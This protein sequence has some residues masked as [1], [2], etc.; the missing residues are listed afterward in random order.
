MIDSE[1]QNKIA[2]VVT[3]YKERALDVM[4]NGNPV[5]AMY[6]AMIAGMYSHTFSYQSQLHF[7]N[8]ELEKCFLLGYRASRD[9]ML[10]EHQKRLERMAKQKA[11]QKANL[12][13]AKKKYGKIF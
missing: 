5:G 7:G 11:D 13:S 2:S 3:T 9:S 10:E 12:V 4:A 6:L 1:K 8:G